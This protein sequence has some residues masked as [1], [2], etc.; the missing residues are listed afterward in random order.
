MKLP[1]FLTKLS[2]VGETLSSVAAGEDFLFHAVTEKNAQ[3][4]VRTA[5]EG[6]SLWEADY[7]LQ[8]RSGGDAEKR[9][10]DIRIA[11]AGGRTL[12]PAYLAE[13]ARTLGGADDAEIDEDFSHYRVSL[14]AI[15]KNRLPQDTGALERALGRLKPAHLDVEVIPVG[16]VTGTQPRFSALHGSMMAEFRA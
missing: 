8:D 9:R 14:H 10:L 13:L 4:C 12:T 15:S 1:E 11:I 7:G 3:L 2:P 16:D 6:L 5:T